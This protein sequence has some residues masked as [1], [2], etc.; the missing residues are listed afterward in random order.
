MQIPGTC[1]ISET[2]EEYY[3]GQ[4]VFSLTASPVSEFTTTFNTDLTDTVPGEYP[5]NYYLQTSSDLGVTWVTVSSEVKTGSTKIIVSGT[6]AVPVPLD[7]TGT[8]DFV[9]VV[10]F[11]T[12]AQNNYGGY[13]YIKLDD[14]V[15]NFLI[16]YVGAGKLV[17]N[18][19]RT[20]VLFFAKRGLQEFS[21]DTINSIKSLEYIVSPSLSIPLPQD[22][23]S[24]VQ[25]SY[26]DSAGI[27]HIIYQANQL[28]VN[29]SSTPQQDLS[30]QFVQDNYGKNIEDSSRTET[31]WKENNP[32]SV[33]GIFNDISPDY[34]YWGYNQINRGERYGGSPEFMQQNGWFTINKRT[35]CLN[36]S[37]DLAQANIVTEYVTDGLAYDEDTRVPKMAEEAMYAHILYMIISTRSG[38]PEY[39]VQRLKKDRSAKLRN[40]KIRL[41]PIG[42]AELTRI[43][44]GKSKWIKH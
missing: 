11:E 13:E 31:N 25:T 19:K 12:A 44:R 42:I 33:T 34:N 37:N 35:N 30:G 23:V 40:A 1:L 28:T 41:S 6:N 26:T 2:N 29:P 38:Q 14:I 5:N 32:S 4:K 9:R 39:V 18:V 3:V 8:I 16:A 17:S 10:L 22:F 36:F 15:T 27:K 43:M 20:D 24:H 7:N 21:Y